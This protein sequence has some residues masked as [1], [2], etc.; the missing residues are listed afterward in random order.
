MCQFP[1]ISGRSL[2][3][4]ATHTTQFTAKNVPV[5]YLSMDLGEKSW[6]LGFTVGMGQRPRL[7]T[8]K[9]RDTARLLLEVAKAKQRFDL[10]EET[11]V[12]SCYEAGRDGFWLHRFL[13][14]HSIANVVV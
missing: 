11:P 3:M 7:R 14:H 5:L 2:A 6:T 13:V 10:P 4:T 8:I 9:A 1:T 12:L